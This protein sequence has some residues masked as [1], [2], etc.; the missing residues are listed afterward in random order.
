LLRIGG[1]PGRFL[2]S[3]IIYAP[4]DQFSPLF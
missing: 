4:V 2:V 3:T 1:T